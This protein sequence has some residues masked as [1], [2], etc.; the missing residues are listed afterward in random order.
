LLATGQK[1]RC[2][3]GLSY[4][5]R[6]YFTPLIMALQGA[7][8]D[9]EFIVTVSDSSQLEFMLKNSLLDISMQQR[10]PGLTGV[11]AIELDDVPA[12]VVAH[13]NLTLPCSGDIITL[14]ELGCLPLLLIKRINGVGTYEAILDGL[15]RKGRNPNIVMSI[16]DSTSVLQYVA[17]EMCAATVVPRSEITPFHSQRCRILQLVGAPS[18]YR[19]VIYRTGQAPCADILDQARQ[20]LAA[21]RVAEGI[22]E[23]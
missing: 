19:P 20:F 15:L 14:D 6:Q 3:I 5:Y 8:R 4:L 16:S 21:A 2:H 12:V 11:E 23:E 10:A 1:Q 13:R 18:L 9:L 17:T 22:S 7:Y